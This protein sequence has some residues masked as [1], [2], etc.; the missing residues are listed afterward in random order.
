MSKGNESIIDAPV[1]FR[2]ERIAEDRRVVERGREGAC[3]GT[4][5]NDDGAL[6]DTRGA[7]DRSRG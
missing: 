4:S 7:M 2:H 6:S 3:I 5:F 1:C